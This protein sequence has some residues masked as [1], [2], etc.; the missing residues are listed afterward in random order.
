MV[1]TGPESWFSDYWNDGFQCWRGG[2]VLPEEWLYVA[3]RVALKLR[4]GGS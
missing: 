2:S 4:T 3:G 1:S